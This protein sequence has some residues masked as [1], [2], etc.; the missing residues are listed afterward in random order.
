[1]S[2]AHQSDKNLE[3]TELLQFFVS[4]V[5]TAK[6][7]FL[8][9]EASLGQIFIAPK[10]TND[11][12]LNKILEESLLKKNALVIY[13][14]I[15]LLLMDTYGVDKCVKY[16]NYWDEINEIQTKKEQ[17]ILIEDYENCLIFRDRQ[18]LL[19]GDIEKNL[20]VTAIEKN[21]RNIIA[22]LEGLFDIGQHSF[23]I[24]KF[25]GDFGIELLR[26]IRSKVESFSLLDI[27]IDLAES[28]QGKQ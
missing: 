23:F 14:Q 27:R 24:N 18:K 21:I 1:M 6:A 16:L 17:A 19:M 9:N 20:I 11:L 26:E 8:K 4:N 22:H 2:S 25:F 7:L 28:C 12:P 15:S 13:L 10:P 5:Q 3:R